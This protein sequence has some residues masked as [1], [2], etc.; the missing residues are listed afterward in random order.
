MYR[1]TLTCAGLSENE[2]ANA[3]NDVLE[4]FSHRSWHTNVKCYFDGTLLRLTAENDFDESGLALLD[5]FGDAI[6]ACVSYSGAIHLE[7]ESVVKFDA[8]AA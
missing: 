8:S 3:R 5:E 4:E 7:I 1:I 6:H 2:G